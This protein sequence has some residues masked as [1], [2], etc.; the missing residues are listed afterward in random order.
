MRDLQYFENFDNEQDFFSSQERQWLV[1][2]LL[3]SIRAKKSD[4]DVVP[5]TILLEGQPIGGS[6]RIL[7]SYFNFN[8]SST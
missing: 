1:L 5:G 4:M 2:R 7:F 8:I 6:L 3:E